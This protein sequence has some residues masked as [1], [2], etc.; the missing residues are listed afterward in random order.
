MDGYDQLMKVIQ[1]LKCVPVTGD[2]WLV[3]QA[4]VNSI[5]QVAETLRGQDNAINN[6]TKPESSVP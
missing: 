5:K 2:Y 4:C 1:A 3:M 6:D